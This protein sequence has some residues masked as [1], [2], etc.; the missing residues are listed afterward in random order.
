M[1]EQRDSHAKLR[2]AQNDEGRNRLSLLQYLNLA[3]GKE[4]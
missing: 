1:K 3:Y 2:F 4:D